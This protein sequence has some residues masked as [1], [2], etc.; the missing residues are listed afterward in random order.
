MRPVVEPTDA[1][2]AIFAGVARLGAA[3]NPF[4]VHTTISLAGADER[5]VP[6]T[7][8]DV[9]GRTVKQLEIRSGRATWDGTDVAGRRLPSGVYFI[10]A[11]EAGAK[12]VLI[13]R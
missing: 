13:L 5:R 8:V 4:S 10:R 3:P 9:T 12:R 1:E 2:P 6:L 7:I 11:P